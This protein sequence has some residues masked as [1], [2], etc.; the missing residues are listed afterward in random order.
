MLEGVWDLS[1]WSL[2]F[3]WILGFIFW[4][5]FQG[6]NH[7]TSILQKQPW[8]SPPHRI[9]NHLLNLFIM[10]NGVGFMSR[11]EIKNPS[12]TTLPA[13]AT[14]EYLATFEPGDENYFIGIGNVESLAVHFSVRQFDKV[15]NSL[16]NLVT[17]FDIPQSFFF[18]SLP[19]SK[20][21]VSAH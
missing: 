1:F 10:I 15:T 16:C 21:T 8:L 4:D 14:T 9:G 17:G 13:A 18:A 11:S 3:I 5:F 6:I 7:W 19:P 2:K 20:R 12:M